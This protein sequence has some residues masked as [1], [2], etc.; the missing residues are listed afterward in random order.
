MD[1]MDTTK[2]LVHAFVLF[3]SSPYQNTINKTDI[4]EKLLRVP[5]LTAPVLQ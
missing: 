3:H 2:V 1:T 5:W 4:L